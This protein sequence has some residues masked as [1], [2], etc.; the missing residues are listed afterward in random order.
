MH[1]SDTAKSRKTR[2]D[3]FPLTLHP[4]GQYC[5]KIKGKLHY[6][7]TQKQQALQQYIERAAMLHSGK[8]QNIVAERQSSR[9]A[10]HYLEISMQ[11]IP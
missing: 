10:K 1:K 7:G 5:K 4:T 8:P 9:T 11:S 6:F 3:K 2:S